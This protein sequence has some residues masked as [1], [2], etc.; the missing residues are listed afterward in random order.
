MYRKILELAK[1]GVGTRVCLE[2]RRSELNSSRGSYISSALDYCRM[3]L[4]Y[5][6]NHKSD[7]TSSSQS[8]GS[9]SNQHGYSGYGAQLVNSL[10]NRL[11][12]TLFPPQSSFFRIVFSDETQAKLEKDGYSLSDLSPILAMA[13]NKAMQ[14]FATGGYRRCMTDVMKHLLVTGNV[15]MYAPPD[16]KARAIPLNRYYT[17]RDRDGFVTE[18]LLVDYVTYSSLSSEEQDAVKR[19]KQ[20]KDADKLPLYTWGCYVDKKYHILQTADSILVRDTKTSSKENLPWNFLTWNLSYGEDYG[21][22]HVED[23]AGDFFVEEFLSESIAVGAAILSDVKYLIRQ[24]STIDPDELISTPSGE[25]LYGDIDDIGVLQLQKYADY[26]PIANILEDYRQRLGR[27][28]LTNSAQRRNAERVTAYE[29]RLDAQELETSLGGVYTTLS[30]TLQAPLASI[31]IKKINLNLPSSNIKPVL[32]T[33][34]EA[35]GRIG[36]LE[37]IAQF[38]EM[39]Q[40]P[41]TWPEG[42]QQRMKWD[43][44]I[45]SIKA[46]LSLEADWLMTEEEYQEAQAQQQQA[47]EGQMVTQEAAKAA[48]ALIEAQMLGTNA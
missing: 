39:V 28:F 35:L 11:V 14:A 17:K 24:G 2:S 15:A 34:I 3:T 41:N 9:G 21:R 43:L 4:P 48:P 22:G 25:Y 16:G 13:E 6:L 30:D 36:D 44:Y 31:L 47:A 1:A 37:K 42:V 27:S 26:T 8:A 20:Y 19:H 46:S 18:F 32:L 29:I 12:L 33:G 5:L 38:S 10:S 45:N 40:I 7:V 23:S